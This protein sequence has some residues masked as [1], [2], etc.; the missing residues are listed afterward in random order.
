VARKKSGK[1][2]SRSALMKQED[3]EETRRKEV[4][5]FSLEGLSVHRRTLALY[6]GGA[7]AALFVGSIFAGAVT[8]AANFDVTLSESFVQGK[9]GAEVSFEVTVQN[10]AQL[11]TYAYETHLVGVPPGWSVVQGEDLFG[12]SAGQ[13]RVVGVRVLPGGATPPNHDYSMEVLVV[14]K[15]TDGVRALE[16]KA[17]TVTV[18]LL[19]S[20]LEVT[21]LARGSTGV[22]EGGAPE[23]NVSF[24]ACGAPAAP[25]ALPYPS[26]GEPTAGGVAFR[27]TGPNLTA[28]GS[29]EVDLGADGTYELNR[30]LNFVEGRFELPPDKLVEWAADHPGSGPNA[31]IPLQFRSCVAGSGPWN[32]T[33][34]A[35]MLS[36]LAPLRPGA[37]YTATFAD[38][39][40]P[41]G[42]A[43]ISLR[44]TNHEDR[45]LTAVVRL[46]DLPSG[47]SSSLPAGGTPLTLEA[48]GG[49]RNTEFTLNVAKNATVGLHDVEVAACLQANER[50]CTAAVL[51]VDVGPTEFFEVKVYAEPGSIKTG[52]VSRPTDI[53]LFVSNLGNQPTA[54]VPGVDL[55]VPEVTHTFWYGDHE[56]V[57]D[58]PLG[59]NVS[60][61]R[62]LVL[63]VSVS[64]SAPQSVAQVHPLF[65]STTTSQE[66]R[67]FFNIQIQAFPTPDSDGPIRLGDNVTVEYTV[68][69]AAGALLF[70][71]NQITF[72]SLLDSGARPTHPN[73]TKP[74]GSSYAPY[75][76]TL[77]N[78]TAYAGTVHE[79]FEAFLLGAYREETLV[80][81]L[82]PDETK[83]PAGSPIHDE[84]V[85]VELKVIGLERA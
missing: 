17:R 38:T 16:S 36:Y 10:T 25:V 7:V 33:L 66:T 27:L 80:L 42:K 34:S 63:R 30:T 48:G 49:T 54:F 40:S 77:R 72:S 79:G 21:L 6:L 20:D 26:D 59:L 62:F 61:T 71:T 56:M 3:A 75:Q 24:T 73:Y 5:V 43:T 65:K 44:A 28:T 60:E 18:K 35:P 57:T 11:S 82:S 78:A 4:P 41:T 45:N 52:Y 76:F 53:L 81:W 12:L 85:V 47:W 68:A 50:D 55:N 32:V 8:S 64:P 2:S 22:F 37:N 15:T 9:A 29:I 19:P 70:K 39:Q 14:A 46:P 23:A 31:S 58:E 51:P 1:S 67:L 69:T 13:S 83:Y 84:V 74:A